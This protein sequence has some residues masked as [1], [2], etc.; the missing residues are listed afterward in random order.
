MARQ[1]GKTKAHKEMVAWLTAENEWQLDQARQAEVDFELEI[2][3]SEQAVAAIRM[4]N[5]GA[6]IVQV[7]EKLGVTVREASDLVAMGLRAILREPAEN[8]IAN[9]QAI[10]R[11]VVRAMYAPMA[12]G[13]PQASRQIIM[14][15]DHQAKLFGLYAPTRVHVGIT[16]EDFA[17]TATRLMKS[18]G[19]TP[20]QQAI[21]ASPVIDAETDDWVT[22]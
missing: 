4:R 12:A 15:L 20:P 5:A 1:S 14:A 9:Q 11:D 3:R 21:E 22:D 6:S 19:V 18:I 2:S 16:D 8:L 10:V 17:L 7:S 13:D